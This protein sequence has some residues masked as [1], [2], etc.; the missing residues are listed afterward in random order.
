[1][2]KNK[3]G[4]EVR[5]SVGIHSVLGCIGS[6]GNHSQKQFKYNNE[7]GYNDVAIMNS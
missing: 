6:Y 2:S 1:M 3:I 4:S 7:Y 5:V